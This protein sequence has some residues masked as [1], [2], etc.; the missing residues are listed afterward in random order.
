M[1]N[2]ML[3]LSGALF[4]LAAGI[5]LIAYSVHVTRQT[6]VRRVDTIRSP[7]IAAG[8]ARPSS[9]R[10][11]MLVR[12]KTQGQVQQEQREMIRWMTKLGIAQDRAIAAF[13]VA[14][15]ISGGVFTVSTLLL[16]LRYAGVGDSV[17]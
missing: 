4:F 15:M 14:R 5:G 16:A 10:D 13:G 11:A 8:N 2:G 9:G 6:L 17:P 3:A 12:L 7:D 1:I